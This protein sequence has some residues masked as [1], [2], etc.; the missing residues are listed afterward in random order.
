MSQAR[1]YGPPKAEERSYGEQRTDRLETFLLD[2]TRPRQNPARAFGFQVDEA[3]TLAGFLR[4]ALH[5]GTLTLDD[6]RSGAE[7]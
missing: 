6:F 3:R 5:D 4:A 2:A 1:C 7:S